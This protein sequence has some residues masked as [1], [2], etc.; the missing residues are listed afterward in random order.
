MLRGVHR[1]IERTEMTGTD[2]ALAEQR[3][4]LQ[5][6]AG[7]KRERALRAEQDVREIVPRRIRRKGIKI[8][9]ADPALYFGKARL[10]LVGLAQADV[11]QVGRERAQRRIRRQVG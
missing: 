8:I 6:D 5:F 11:E 1:L 3:R 7:R 4:E 9:A 10:D 2:R